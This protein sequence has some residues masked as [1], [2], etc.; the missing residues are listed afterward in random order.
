MT[1]HNL[2]R[3]IIVILSI[4]LSI[5]FAAAL[6]VFGPNQRPRVDINALQHRILNDP[7]R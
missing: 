3:D 7:G 1:S 2:K 4:K 6:F 5:V